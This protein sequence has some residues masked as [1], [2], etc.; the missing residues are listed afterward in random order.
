MK[1]SRFVLVGLFAGVLLFSATQVFG[2]RGPS[3]W[4]PPTQQ[5]PGGNTTAPVDIGSDNQTKSGELTTKAYTSTRVGPAFTTAPGGYFR[6]G[7]NTF[8]L[9]ASG[10]TSLLNLTGPFVIQT[11]GVV[12]PNYS[13]DV[14][15]TGVPAGTL[16]Y[17]NG[18]LW[19]FTGGT[20][21]TQGQ[22][23]AFIPSANAQAGRCWV[24]VGGGGGTINNIS[25]NFWALGRGGVYT[26]TTVVSVGATNG[27]NF[28][29]QVTA[30]AVNFQVT[31]GGGGNQTNNGLIN[32]ANAQAGGTTA[33]SIDAATGNVTAARPLTAQGTFTAQGAVTA[34]NDVKLAPT[35][36]TPYTLKNIGGTLSFVNNANATQLSVGQDGMMLIKDRL[37]AQSGPVQI[38]GSSGS[39]SVLKVGGTYGG[40]FRP[41]RIELTHPNGSD[42]VSL[43]QEFGKTLSITDPNHTGGLKVNLDNVLAT[44]CFNVNGIGVRKFLKVDAQGWLV[45]EEPNP[46]Q[47]FQ[48][49]T[50]VSVNRQELTNTILPTANYFCALTG[51]ESDDTI[52]FGKCNVRVNG[53]N[54]EMNMKGGGARGLRCTARCFQYR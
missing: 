38:V 13:T 17:N 29:T 21:C 16:T 37:A 18:D 53:T 6:S 50:W 45:C 8:Y 2:Q 36:V 51:F 34:Q 14:L 9:D 32:S 35:N 43:K 4:T 1:L 48:E 33:L 15:G 19:L 25:A 42:T 40:T 27:V 10:Y 39:E 24:K 49:F 11:K 28:N 20:N 47:Q 26:T 5:F 31:N 46:T 23:E 22:Q 7:S 44:T 52:Q 30:N 41:G 54:W 3:T 12:L